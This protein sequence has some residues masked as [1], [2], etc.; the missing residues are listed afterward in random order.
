MVGKTPQVYHSREKRDARKGSRVA[1]RSIGMVE[2]AQGLEQ[3][4]AQQRVQEVP[5]A[6]QQVL[7]RGARPAREHHETPPPLVLRQLP[8]LVLNLLPLLLLPLLLV[9]LLVLLVLLHAALRHA[10][11]DSLKETCSHHHQHTAPQAP[12]ALQA[13]QAKKHVSQLGSLGV[14]FCGGG[15]PSF[16]PLPL[17]LFLPLLPGAI[18]SASLHFLRAARTLDFNLMREAR[19][20]LRDA[21]SQLF[22]FWPSPT[23]KTKI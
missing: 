10:A 7:E 6:Q 15:L 2:Q 4:G 22:I 3:M 19:H 12:Q 1:R 8:P 21:W 11:C 17:P 9:V 14:S 5:R 23:G 13:L 18:K 20:F 16:L